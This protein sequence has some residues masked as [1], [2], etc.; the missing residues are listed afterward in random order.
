M[1]GGL[2][3]EASPDRSA[4]RNDRKLLE[5]RRATLA[6]ELSALC[7]RLARS[8]SE[9]DAQLAASDERLRNWDRART[10]INET[11]LGFP[12]P[13]TATQALEH[14]ALLAAEQSREAIEDILNEL[15]EQR[16]NQIVEFQQTRLDFHE[17][18]E[19]HELKIQQINE[20]LAQ[21][22]GAFGKRSSADEVADDGFRPEP[23]P[24]TRTT[25]Q[26][27]MQVLEEAPGPM[28]MKDVVHR[29]HDL[30]S[31]ST[32]ATIRTLLSKLSKEERVALVRRGHYALADVP[33]SRPREA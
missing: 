23:Q 6:G 16:R 21:L 18:H 30:G 7:A 3:R 20:R 10:K 5:V 22:N 28:R 9:F 11:L 13:D 24:N 12:P 26:L 14:K 2:D 32:E 33:T 8:Q 17:A 15:E 31:R 25:R 29:V 27:V 19:N 4:L 1:S